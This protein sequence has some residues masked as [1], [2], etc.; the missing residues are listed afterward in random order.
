MFNYKILKDVDNNDWNNQLKESLASSFFQTYEY[1]Q[2]ESSSK[3]F[4]MFIYIFDEKNE[5]K[6]QLG[7]IV[8]QSI[9]I[10]SSSILRKCFSNFS[11]LS[12][13]IS[14]A[15]GPI[16]YEENNIK[17]LKIIQELIKALEEISQ[18]F[19]IAIIDGYTPPYDFL[20][21]NYLNTLT[22]ENYNIQKFFTFITELDINIDQIWNKIYKN[23]SRDILRAEKREIKIKELETIEEL[24]Q[25]FNLNSKWAKTKG[26]E[27]S[28]DIEYKKSY[29]KYYQSKKEKIF[30]A[31]EGDELVTGH[32]LGCFNGIIY[33]HLVTNSYLKPTSLGGP[34]LTWHAIKWAKE[35]G[36]K[37]YDFS[38][39][40]TPPLDKSQNQKY[41][42]QWGSLL[43]YKS[44]WGGN[45][46]PYY[47]IFK[48]N[49]KTSY[50]L[51]R[52]LVKID[53][54]YRNYKEKH[55]KRPTKK[56]DF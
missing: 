35:S 2:C 7:V 17:R 27:S 42:K 49:R 38:G 25:Y 48:I 47:H 4:P 18:S 16:L 55:S 24:E 33:S 28:L 30:L 43:K 26:I 13:K 23:T 5:I 34:L 46:F 51:F 32:R 44:R 54:Y 40:E 3:N 53:G 21:N 10:Y 39:G 29:W 20:V 15:G 11:S 50:K 36:Y 56:E 8:R 1:L 9:S 52:I 41:E 45:E 12:R 31:Y 14:W 6:A 22:E 19:N 37:K